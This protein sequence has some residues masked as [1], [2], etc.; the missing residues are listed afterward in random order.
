VPP[1]GMMLVEPPTQSAN[2]QATC[3]MGWVEEHPPR[4]VRLAPFDQRSGGTVGVGDH[5]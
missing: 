5:R 4:I 1:Q 3:G 2:G